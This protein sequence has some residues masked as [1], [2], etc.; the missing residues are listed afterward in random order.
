MVSWFQSDC[1]IRVHIDV[2]LDYNNY[3]KIFDTNSTYFTKVIHSLS[4]SDNVFLCVLML[5]SDLGLDWRTLTV[6]TADG[7][8]VRKL[9]CV[10]VLF[11]E[12]F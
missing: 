3:N 5:I 7:T 6:T 4:G 8:V 2:G 9:N 12:K 10:T 11:S 1:K